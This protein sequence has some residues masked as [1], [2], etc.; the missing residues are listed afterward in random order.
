MVLGVE[1][2]LCE[3]QLRKRLTPIKAQQGW[4]NAPVPGAIGLDYD[5]PHTLPSSSGQFELNVRPAKVCAFSK[6]LWEFL[7]GARRLP[8]EVCGHL[9]GNSA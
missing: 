1:G 4:G 2:F 3:D 9:N 7:K 8:Y 6:L 5:H